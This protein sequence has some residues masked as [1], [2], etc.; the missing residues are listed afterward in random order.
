ML[1]REKLNHYP[2]SGE[3]IMPL[4]WH[5]FIRI[6]GVSLM[7]LF[8]P[9]FVFL[10]G[11]EMGGLAVGIQVMAGYVILERFIGIIFSVPV[12]RLIEKIGCN[13][14][15]LIGCLLLV[16]F[17]SLPIVFGEQ[18]LTLGL[19][20]VAAA[21]STLFYWIPRYSLL[22][23]EGDKR[24]FGH[25]ISVVGLLERASGILAPLVGG[26]V[27]QIFGYKNLFGL[28]AA[29][30]LVSVVPIFSIGKLTVRDGVSWRSYL[31]WIGN[32]KNKHLV[33]AFFGTGM[34]D[35]AIGYYWPI[36]VFLVVGSFKTLGGLVTATTLASVIMAYLAG[37]WF[38]QRRRRV[39]LADEKM[40]WSGGVISAAIH[41]FRPVVMG[42]TGV[43]GVD[44]LDK[45]TYPFY[46]IPYEGYMYS[47][48]KKGSLLE[49]YTYREI[50][51]SVAIIV[52][53]GVV[54]AVSMVSFM[55]MGIFVMGTIGTMLALTM[56]RES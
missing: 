36:Y 2:V 4:Y 38:D 46:R 34:S 25:Q 23:A 14:S 21:I 32:W 28:A 51:Y 16:T 7:G 20:A 33:T 5:V 43:F 42:L 31:K 27:W 56:S 55:W 9:I 47:A 52:G 54:L 41:L 8:F 29:I 22:S 35:F 37:R 12:T 39:G 50:T 19:M 24:S 26:V 3:A 13:V 11:F 44:L 17:Y 45:I 1:V 40:F 48:S 53:A 10:I 15:M 6:M 30:I 18:I 49:F